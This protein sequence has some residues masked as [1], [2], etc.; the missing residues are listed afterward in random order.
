MAISESS[1]ARIT[2]ITLSHVLWNE[3]STP[4]TSIA[5]TSMR[6]RRKGTFSGNFSRC[7]VT[8]KQSPKSMWQMDPEMR[9]IM[10]LLG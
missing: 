5:F 10:M 2:F 7:I 6:V 8:S 1:F 3:P 9:S 4:P